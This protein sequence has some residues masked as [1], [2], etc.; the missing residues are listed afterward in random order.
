VA[1]T[2]DVPVVAGDGAVAT[3]E[4]ARFLYTIG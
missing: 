2:R 1:R 3:V 4:S